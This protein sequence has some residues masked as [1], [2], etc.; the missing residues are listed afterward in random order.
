MRTGFIG[1]GNMATAMVR[2]ILKAKKAM[3]GEIMV[4]RR[5]MEPLRELH[6]ELGIQITTDNKEVTAF[7][8]ILVS[9]QDSM[10]ISSCSEIPE[11]S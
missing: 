4:S 1:C 3:P 10:A 11:K 8:D 2:G 6:K 5:H 9:R 7:S